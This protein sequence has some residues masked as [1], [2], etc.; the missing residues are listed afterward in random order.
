MNGQAFRCVHLDH[1]TSA[2][3]EPVLAE[4]ERGLKGRKLHETACAIPLCMKVIK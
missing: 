3:L 4:F 2:Q 1:P